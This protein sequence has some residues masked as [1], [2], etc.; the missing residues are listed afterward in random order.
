MRLNFISV[1]PRPRAADDTGDK[2]RDNDGLKVFTHV[3]S[4]QSN[5]VRRRGARPLIAVTGITLLSIIVKV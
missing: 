1:D 5:I 4:P 3:M 2:T